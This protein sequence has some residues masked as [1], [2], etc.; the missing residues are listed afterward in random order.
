MSRLNVGYPTQKYEDVKKPGTYPV[1]MKKS[2]VLEIH[3]YLFNKAYYSAVLTTF[4]RFIVWV[5][6]H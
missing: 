5:K 1:L 3:Y 4:N 2:E 6:G